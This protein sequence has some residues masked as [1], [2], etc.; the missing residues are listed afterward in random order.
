MDPELFTL[1]PEPHPRVES[2]SNISAVKPRV[3]GTPYSESFTLNP[4]A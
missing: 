4:D 3:P 1:N 2:S